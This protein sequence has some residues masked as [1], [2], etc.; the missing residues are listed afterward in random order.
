MTLIEKKHFHTFT[1]HDDRQTPYAIEWW[2]E[3]LTGK[4]KWSGAYSENQENQRVRE[5]I[6][7]GSRPFDFPRNGSF[8]LA[9]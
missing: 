7:I 4:S 6:R 2:R 9:R 1:A 5:P 3:R 8:L